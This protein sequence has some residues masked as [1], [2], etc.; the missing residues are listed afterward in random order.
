MDLRGA[1]YGVLTRWPRGYNP[2]KLGAELSG[3]ASGI[4]GLTGLAG[5]RTYYLQV[6]RTYPDVDFSS[7]DFSAD[8]RLQQAL[9]EWAQ[10]PGPLAALR[11]AVASEAVGSLSLRSHRRGLP[12]E[13]S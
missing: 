9:H 13:H 12:R 5:L 4:G 8:V 10:R 1:R 3:T 7:D 11:F 6:L 2:K